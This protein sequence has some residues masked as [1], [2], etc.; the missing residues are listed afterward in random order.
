MLVDPAPVRPE[1]S[2]GVPRVQPLA[3]AP[4]GS[5]RRTALVDAALVCIA[6]HGTVKTTVDD[7]ARQAGVSRA[8]VYR[9]FPG[10]KEELLTAVADT[11][12]A[13]LFS[14]LGA[15]MGAADELSDVLV[16]GIVEA[17]SRIRGHAALAYLVEHEPDVVLGQLCFDDAE[18]LLSMAATF[19]AP[20][21]GRWM[22]ADEAVRVAEWV[23]RIVL[24]YTITPSATVDLAR[25]TDAR[26]L[27]ETF[28]LPG[29]QALDVAEP[30]TPGDPSGGP[31]V[32]AVAAVHAGTDGPASAGGAFGA[33]AGTRAR[34][35]GAHQR[36]IG[37]RQLRRPRSFHRERGLHHG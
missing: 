32:A 28:V 29:I 9:V 24:S 16:V 23:A 37:T 6:R 1:A 11:E 27:V 3:G 26:R 22:D 2:A 18:R 15:R 4:S 10:G 8:T 35:E 25:E 33:P 34:T 7:V 30:A 31:A 17:T 13:R 14:A 21:L 20:F 12:R 36:D 5:S 19:V